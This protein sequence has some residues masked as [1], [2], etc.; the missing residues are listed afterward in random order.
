MIFYTEALPDL[1]RYIDMERENKYVAAK[2]KKRA[3]ENIEIQALDKEYKIDLKPPYALN[4]EWFVPNNRHDADNIYFKIK[5]ILDGLVQAKVLPGDG[6]KFV[7]P[8]K[9]S[10][11][12]VKGEKEHV[13]IT[14]TE[15]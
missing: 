14:I 7:G 2:I 8:I 3:T 11:F 9:N 5:F 15:V 4:C 1:N 6:R 12:T 13:R 10:I